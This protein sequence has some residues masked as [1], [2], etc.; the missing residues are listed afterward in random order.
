MMDVYGC[1]TAQIYVIYKSPFNTVA[2]YQQETD[3]NTADVLY[4]SD[5]DV[6]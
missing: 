4:M 1:L 6:W 3:V 2:S 5:K